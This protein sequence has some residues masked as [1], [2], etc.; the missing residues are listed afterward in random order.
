MEVIKHE[1]DKVSVSSHQISITNYNT[2]REL[3]PNKEERFRTSLIE[4]ARK[5]MKNRMGFNYKISDK[6][7]SLC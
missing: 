3:N 4:R 6:L 2:H 5:N 7:Y 1:E